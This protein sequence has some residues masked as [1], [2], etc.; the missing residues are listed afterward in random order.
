MLNLDFFGNNFFL[1]KIFPSGVNN[2]IFIKNIS[3]VVNGNSSLDFFIKQRPEIDVKKW[4]QFGI[5]FN[6]LWIK[7]SN[8][9]NFSKV[10]IENIQDLGFSSLEINSKDFCFTLYSSNNNSQLLLVLDKH[11]RFI[12]QDIT[13][14]MI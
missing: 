12:I 7:T 8:N 5:D 10:I 2:H 4:G 3:T 13:P 14:I 1:K 11:H 9:I 6:A